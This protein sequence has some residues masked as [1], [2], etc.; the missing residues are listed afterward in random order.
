MDGVLI[1][2]AGGLIEGIVA[3][4]SCVLGDSTVGMEGLLTE[5]GL[6]A[7][8]LSDT[9]GGLTIGTLAAGNFVLS[10]GADGTFGVLT[11]GWLTTGVVTDGLLIEVGALSAGTEGAGGIVATELGTLT[12]GRLMLDGS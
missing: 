5:G 2:A 11:E 6:I 3:D 4:G 10:D 1:D 7:G 9:A 12:V 8:V